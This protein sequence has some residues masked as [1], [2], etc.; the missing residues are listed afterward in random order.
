[1]PSF[2]VDVDVWDFMSELSDREIKEVVEY[3]RDNEE[4]AYSFGTSSKLSF[5]DQQLVNSLMLIKENLIQLTEE[6][7]FIINNIAKRL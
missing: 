4:E 7:Q 3:L 1:M 2:S 6:E 5:D